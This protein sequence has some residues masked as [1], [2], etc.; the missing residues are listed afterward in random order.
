M[1]RSLFFSRLLLTILVSGVLLFGLHQIPVF[2][3]HWPVSVGAVGMFTAISVG[4][5][6]WGEATAVSKNKLAFNGLIT[7][8]VLGKIVFSLVGLMIYFKTQNPADRLFVV[9]F[10]LVYVIFTIFETWFLLR[11]AKT[12]S[13]N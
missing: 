5:F 3:K 6:F 13:I 10:L 9:P 1:T 11:L 7:G 8:S 12:K 4:L 2:Q